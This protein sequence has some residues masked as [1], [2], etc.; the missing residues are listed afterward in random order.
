MPKV[1]INPDKCKS[2]YLC[3]AACPKKVLK[4][5]AVSGKTGNGIVEFD[6]SQNKC[7]GCALCAISCPD[8]AITE[9]IK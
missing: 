2:C 5:S 1:I 7:I 4:I 3:V 8:M 9:V 6:N